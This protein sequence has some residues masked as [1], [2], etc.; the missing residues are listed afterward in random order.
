MIMFN[1]V[2]FDPTNKKHLD[3]Y[4]SFLLESRWSN[5][6]TVCPFKLEQPW[7]SIPHMIQDKIVRAYFDN[8]L[9]KVTN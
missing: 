6:N 1:K 9:P 5:G 3:Q 8:Q 4:K 7:L 2:V